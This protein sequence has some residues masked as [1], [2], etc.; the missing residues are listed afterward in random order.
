MVG[1]MMESSIE[2]GI[3]LL[4]IL[5][6]GGAYVPID[7]HYPEERIQHIIQDSQVNIII[8]QTHIKNCVEFTGE[9]LDVLD[10]KIM[11]STVRI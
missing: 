3:G 10:E 11:I 8:T 7:P 2:M 1:I 5:K 4:A 9:W 6:A